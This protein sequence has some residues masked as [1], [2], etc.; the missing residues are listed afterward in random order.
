MTL[1]GKIAVVTG[2][3][4]GIGYETAVALA[5]DG[6]RVFA[7]ARRAD[8]LQA[9]QQRYPQLIHPV[10][11]DIRDKNLSA[12]RDIA[13]SHSVDILVNNAGLAKGRDAVQSATIE[14]ITEMFETNVAAL[15]RVTKVFLSD[16]LE[17]KSGDI[18]NIGSVAGLH[19]YPGGSMYCATKAAVHMMSDG[20]RMELLGK[21]IRVTE[22][23]P[24]M[25]ETE[26]SQVR[27]GGNSELSRKTYEGMRPLKGAD[28]AEAILWSLKRPPHVNIQSLLIMPT[29]Q[30]GVGFVHREPIGK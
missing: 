3:S 8:K 27:F 13:G 19:A 24:G 25:A 1:G 4:A 14:D 23:L 6:V 22:I 20:W 11:Q 21:G 29:D 26:F 18:I 17:R 16:M 7:V 30:G 12:L 10:V 15:I 5:A 28:I 2:A 9:L